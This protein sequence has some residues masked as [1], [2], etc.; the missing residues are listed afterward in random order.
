M[1]LGRRV[2]FIGIG[3][4]GMS[5]LASLLLAQGA[6]VSGSDLQQNAET[7]RLRSFGAVVRRGH[8]A[9]WLPEDVDT[10]VVSSAIPGDNVE[11]QAAFERRTPILRRL[12]A[13]GAVMDGY[14]SVGVA[15]THGK[16]TTTAMTATLFRELGMDPSFL[17]GAHCPNLGGNAHLGGGAWFV[18]EIDE[19]DGLFTSLRPTIGVL[20]NVGRDHLQTYRSVE[21]MEDAFLRYIHGVQKAVLSIDDPRVRAIAGDVRNALTVGLEPDAA[22]RAERLLQDRFH[23]SFD[24]RL[25]G[26]VLG[27]YEIAA[28]GVHNVR[29]A[30]CALG[31]VIQAGADPKRAAAS[32]PA[33]ALPHR[34]FEVLEENGVTVV[35]D[36]AHTPEEV[37][38]TLRAIRAG[39]AG[40]RI[41]AIFQPHR[42]TRT[43]ILGPAFGRSFADADVVVVTDIYSA[44]EAPLQNVTQEGIVDSITAQ[45]GVSAYSI[46]HKRDVTEFLKGNIRR[47]DFILSIGAGDIW[48][49]T[50]DLAQFLKEGSFCVA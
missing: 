36:F 12:H 23:T 29:N 28:P 25:Q 1:A 34:R 33:L 10:V 44:S 21:A 5:G 49:V 11:V 13:L 45:A 14:E 27:R 8:A 47:G 24:L 16:S 50:E 26:D 48:T 41:V 31:A 42:Y 22:L 4:S 20:T 2:H 30:L 37:E 32:L 39:W 17:V 43:R 15:G 35:D 7:E 3:G 9:A 19:S 38:A 6:E 18:A 46:P 40:R